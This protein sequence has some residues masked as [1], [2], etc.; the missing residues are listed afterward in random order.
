MHSG[1]GRSRQPPLR[2]RNGVTP[3]S[4]KVAPQ[5]NFA[6]K[7]VVH[8]GQQPIALS[9]IS[10]YAAGK[11]RTGSAA[12]SML[13][14]PVLTDL[15]G[16]FNISGLYSCQAGDQVYLVATGGNAGAGP[17]RPSV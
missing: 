15:N 14:L 6:V 9:Q 1:A 11:T 3:G 10:L 8:G 7:G 12:R 16:G 4:E 13:T 2:L 17:T 5:V